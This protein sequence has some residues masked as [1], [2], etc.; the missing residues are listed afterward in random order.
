MSVP[1]IIFYCVILLANIIQGITGFAGT[2]LAMP[3][4]IMT[5]GFDVARP[6]L[7]GLGI[8]A[9]IMVLVTCYKKINWIEFTRIILVM[10]TGIVIGMVIKHTLAG[11]E[12]ILFMILGAFINVIAVFGLIKMFIPM[13]KLDAAK[14][15][16]PENASIITALI[17]DYFLL[18]GSGIIHG[19]FVSGGPL[20]IAYL[21]RKIK[22]KDSF[23]ATISTVWILLN[24]II[25]ATDCVNGVYTKP[26][27]ITQAISVPFMCAGVVIG[28]FLYKHM[29]QKVFIILTYI[30]LIISGVSLFFK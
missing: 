13:K 19:M 16:M 2:I 3:V 24:G 9:G 30:L 1:Y 23:R 4:S 10:A 27:I 7:N 22:D 29:S 28:G 20:L 25:F 12:K 14:E 26:L 17:A 8:L 5:V 11:K 21:T 6:V 15:K 18:L